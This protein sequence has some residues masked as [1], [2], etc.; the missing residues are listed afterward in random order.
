M[1][2]AAKEQIYNIEVVP[3]MVIGIAPFTGGYS[4]ALSA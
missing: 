2:S 1:I 3:Y 4:E